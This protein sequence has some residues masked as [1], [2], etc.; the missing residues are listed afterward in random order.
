MDKAG[1]RKAAAQLLKDFKKLEGQKAEEYI[2]LNFDE[3][4][5]H[6]DVNKT[7]LVEIERMSQ[8]YKMFL[9]CVCGDLKGPTYHATLKEAKQYCGTCIRC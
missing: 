5:D 9:R 4:W 6:F 1:S 3:L 2:N 7:G 8:F